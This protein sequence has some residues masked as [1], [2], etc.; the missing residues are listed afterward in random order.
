MG[1]GFNITVFIH[2]YT[3]FVVFYG[4]PGEGKITCNHSKKLTT[5]QIFTRSSSPGQPHRG[6]SVA[7]QHLIAAKCCS[8]L[9]RIEPYRMG[10]NGQQEEHQVECP[11]HVHDGDI[12]KATMHLWYPSLTK[13]GHG[14]GD[15]GFQEYQLHP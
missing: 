7:A 1:T 2:F 5:V 6:R 9:I 11:S 13:S 10:H 4:N 14:L 15:A 3:E 12:V 8:T